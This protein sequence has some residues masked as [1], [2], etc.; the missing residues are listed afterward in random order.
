MT[1]IFSTYQKYKIEKCRKAKGGWNLI[2]K[3][4]VSGWYAEKDDV[5][6]EIQKL[7]EDDCWNA[8][9]RD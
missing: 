5:E 3:G 4:V 7:V 9:N 2:V 6:K 1:P 8:A